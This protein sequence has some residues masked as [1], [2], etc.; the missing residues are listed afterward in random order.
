MTSSLIRRFVGLR[1]DVKDAGVRRRYGI[2]SGSVGVAC[3]LCLFFLKLITGLATGYISITADA[4]N[5]LSDMASC[6]V[7]L[8]GFKAV[9][10]PADRKHPY[11]HGRT[12]YIAGQ[13]VSFAIIFMG[14]SLF[15]TSVEQIISPV[16][17][18]FNAAIVVILCVSIAVKMWMWMFNREIGRQMSS[19]S[20]IATARDS[21]NDCI[22]TGS[23]LICL[24]IEHFTGVALDGFAGAGVAVFIFV[25]GIISCKETMDPLLGAMP[26]EETMDSIRSAVLED[27]CILGV[28][29][30]M[31]HDYG[32]GRVYATLHAEVPAGLGIMA[33]H[34]I[35]HAAEKRVTDAVGCEISI[36][37]DPVENADKETIELRKMVS[38][39]LRTMDPKFKMHDFRVLNRG[40]AGENKKISFDVVVPDDSKEDENVI[41]E[42]IAHSI[43][44]WEPDC[45][46]DIM[47]DR[48]FVHSG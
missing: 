47:I 32:P 14:I 45:E 40:L 6:I 5:N 37:M 39:I 44:M 43:K 27:K 33:A 26:S 22:A 23:V 13:I 34:D 36:H 7:M 21:L 24:I 9:G 20:V 25:S 8:I 10:K 28:H 3:N 16:R 19:P 41:R 31:V 4:L 11:G 29:D 42:R 48:L 46:A 1:A 12:E 38:K 30:M 18:E 35:I 2:L 15:R 17:S